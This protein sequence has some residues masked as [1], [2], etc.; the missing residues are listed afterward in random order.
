M[1]IYTLRTPNLYRWNS[2]TMLVLVLWVIWFIGVLT[3]PMYSRYA[4]RFLL[5]DAFLL[6][7]KHK[8][9][10]NKP[11]TGSECVTNIIY[12][13]IWIFLPYL[14]LCYVDCKWTGLLYVRS[15]KREHCVYSTGIYVFRSCTIK[16]IGRNNCSIVFILCRFRE[17][18]KG[19]WIRN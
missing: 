14:Y 5:F 9:R 8:G 13:T 7:S 6:Q 11:K 18:I 4:M 1:P 19:N 17:K 12:W 16:Y 3:S 10:I 2:R 15:I